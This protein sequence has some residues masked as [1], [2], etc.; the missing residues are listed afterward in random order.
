MEKMQTFIGLMGSAKAK[1]L[2]ETRKTTRTLVVC[3]DEAAADQLLDAFVF[4]RDVLGQS[5]VQVQRFALRKS[6]LS[7]SH[8]RDDHAC[9]DR[10]SFLH[11]LHQAQTEPWIGI[12]SV[13][14]L[15]QKTVPQDVFAQ[16][17]ITLEKDQ[18]YDRDTLLEN[19]IQSGYQRVHQIEDKGQFA[20]RGDIIDVFSVDQVDPHR[21]EFFDDEVQSIHF[22]HMDTQRTDKASGALQQMTCLP[23]QECFYP[24][25]TAP[26]VKALKELT[27]HRGLPPTERMEISKAFANQHSFSTMDKFIGL[28]Y[29]KG[30]TLADWLPETAEVVWIEPWLIEQEKNQLRLTLQGL[31]ETMTEKKILYPSP[32]QSFRLPPK[33]LDA[34]TQHPSRQYLDSPQSKSPQMQTTF[35]IELLD[36]LRQRLI[37]AQK[38]PSPFQPMQQQLQQWQSQNMQLHISAVD[39][40]SAQQLQRLLAPY[41]KGEPIALSK[42]VSDQTYQMHLGT[43][44]SG[45]VDKQA[46]EVWL[47]Q[48]E[49]LG[50]RKKTVRKPKEPTA[51][52]ESVS[53]LDHGQPVVHMD[54]GIGIYEGLKKMTIAGN[55]QD[56]L[57]L[58]F[59]K[60]DKLFLPVYR[61]NRIHPYISGDGKKPK[62]D[63]L[64]STAWKKTKAHAKKAVEEMASEL[65]ELYAKRKM[66][67]GFV[68][69]PPDTMYQ[70]FEASFPFQET[71]DQ[72][73]TLEDIDKD[74]MSDKPMDRLV[75]GDVGF[76]KTEIALRTAFRVAEAGRQVAVLVPTTILAQQHYETFKQRFEPF[77]VNV[78]FVSRFKSPSEN[79]KTLARLASGQVDIIIGT[80]R[81]LSKDVTF[82]NL[83]LLVLDEEHRFGVKHKE[84]IKTYRNQIDVLTL[85]ATPIPRTLQLSMTGI[86]DLSVINTPPLDRKAVNT[87]LATFDES[88]IFDAT[89]KEIKRGG[90]V[91]FLHNRVETIGSMHTFLQK[92]LPDVRIR[93]GHGQMNQETLEQTMLDFLHHKFD[94]LLCTTIIESGIDVPNANT[95]LINRADTLGL[96]QLYQ[97]RGRVGRSTRD[98]YAY[99][100]IPGEEIITPHALKR[101][102]T[103]KTFTHLGAGL[104]IAM[105][106]LEIRGAGNL[107][108][109]KQSGQIASVGFELY[110][111]LLER[112]VRKLKGEKVVE[113]I[114]PDIQVSMPAMIPENYIYDHQERL[115]MY[116]RLSQCPTMQALQDLKQELRDRFGPHPP[117]LEN[118]FEVIELKILARKCGVASLSITAQS[119]SIAFSDQ[120]NVNVDRLLTLIR[121]DPRFSLTPEHKLTIDFESEIDPYA[122][123]K[124]ILMSLH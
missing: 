94:L 101:L 20:V 80:H 37:Q 57:I 115:K 75:C 17:C 74:L 70:S 24:S 69:P 43:L 67:K 6:D 13:G 55:E 106:D 29:P 59:A 118:L 117:L 89:M 82:A 52:F 28:F 46:N 73:Q 21:I 97:L 103:I 120:A 12:T 109:A 5:Q 44:P 31:E 99:M 85:T 47:A 7:P 88:T 48:N 63:T 122:E 39:S 8:I 66:A 35:D 81:L 95:L 45:F 15:F 10:L 90:Q 107:L 79:K 111:Q 32:Q 49:I 40:K 50:Q 104:K 113:E 102:K 110:A 34:L 84:R 25:S 42:G 121:E 64:G 91:F 3:P 83:G 93:V 65:I 124:K 30:E 61:L 51:V 116:R 18:N 108:G 62:L 38:T 11:H 26:M 4:F 19:L 119:P 1:H 2:L 105:H 27:D 36:E 77:P 14:A 23:C 96:A 98:A 22:F 71:D 92:L 76:G 58:S 9:Y 86:R 16:R 56:F 114:E 33:A 112:E 87:V 78:D 53:D 68:Y 72:I 123:T 60:Q 41:L 100:M 54:H